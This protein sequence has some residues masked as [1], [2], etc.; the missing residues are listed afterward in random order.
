MY[1]YISVITQIEKVE[2]GGKGEMYKTNFI[3][4]L[5]QGCIH[6]I[7][8][9]KVNIRILYRTIHIQMSSKEEKESSACVLF[10]FP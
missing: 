4:R 8:Y 1:I 2:E 10:S 7:T 5:W 6:I 9:I 3:Q